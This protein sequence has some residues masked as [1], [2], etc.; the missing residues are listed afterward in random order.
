MNAPNDQ[1]PEHKKSMEQ[2]PL[3][4]LLVKERKMP[5][6]HNPSDLNELPQTQTLI[7]SPCPS[8]KLKNQ[9]KKNAD[10]FNQKQLKKEK[11][12]VCQRGF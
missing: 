3:L 5:Q 11:C 4:E 8:S 2:N 1:N 12:L 9:W 6:F 10:I 7:L